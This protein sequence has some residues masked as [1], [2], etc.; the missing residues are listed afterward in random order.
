MQ[1]A[2]PE[3]AEPVVGVR[4]DQRVQPGRVE[5]DEGGGAV[6]DQALPVPGGHRAGER[7]DALRGGLGTDAEGQ[8]PGGEPGV[9]GVLG[10]Q[11][12][13]RLGGQVPQLRLVGGGGP[14]AQRGGGHPAGVG[15]GQVGGQLGQGPQQRG[16]GAVALLGHA[17]R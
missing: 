2:Q 7:G 5:P 3:V 14:A 6:A 17:G 12:G 4:V 10:D 13:R 9:R 8:Q 15:V 11:P 16:P 1:G